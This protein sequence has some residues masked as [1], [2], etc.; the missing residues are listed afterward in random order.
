MPPKRP[1]LVEAKE[2]DNLRRNTTSRNYQ[3]RKIR[4]KLDSVII[5]P[6]F[7]EPT[8]EVPTF[9]LTPRDKENIPAGVLRKLSN[10][11][12]YTSRKPFQGLRLKSF[13]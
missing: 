10:R 6:V 4:A 13:R 3:V 7:T 8:S 12:P 2:K 11:S 1:T 5:E 9:L